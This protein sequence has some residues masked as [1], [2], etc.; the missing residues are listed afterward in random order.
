MCLFPFV[1]LVSPPLDVAQGGFRHQRS[2]LDQALCLHDLMR[3]Y[4]DRHNHYPVVAFLDIKAAYDTVDRRIIWQ[5]MLASSAPFCLVSLLANLFDDVS[6][7]VLLNNNVSTPFAPSTGVLQGSVLSPHLYSIYI[8]TLPALL[9]SAA[10]SSTTSVLT[11][12]PSGPPGPGSLVPPGL[13]FGPLA[14]SSALSSSSPSPSPINCLLYADD[15][16]LV[17]SAREVRH[18]LDLAQI[19]SLTLGYKWSPSKC[20]VLNSPVQSSR[21]FVRMSLYDEDL[22]SVDEFI[23]LGIPFCNKGISVSAMVKHRAS[24]TLFAM[25]Q[26]NAIGLNRNGFSL[27]LSARFYASFVRPKLEYGLAIAHL[28]KK[29]YTE[30]NRVQDRC[31]RMIVGGH[32]TSST[33]VLRH[34]CNLPSMDFRA[35]TLVLKYCLRVSGLPDDCLLS[36][37]ASSV[38]LSLLSRLRQRRIVHD[39]PQDASSSTSRLSSWLRR[40]RQERFNTFLQSTSR[41]LIRACRPVLRVDPVLFVPASRADR[42]RLVRWR[43][44]WLPG[45]PRPCAC[46]LGQTSRSHLV[47]CTMVPSY[48]WSCLPF[49]PTSYVGN[50]IDY[51]LNQ[52][53]LSPS[54][55]CPPFWSAL[56]TILW[57]FDRLC[58]P[59]G[60]YTT[61]PTPG[62]VWLDKSQSPS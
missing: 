62:Q 14:G 38:P 41:V 34:I 49:P 18:M 16:A 44:G 60:D 55:S 11:L 6:V 21:S 10:S 17:G 35:D 53:P 40:Y 54:A 39:C 23:Y 61:D 56:C 19:H 52:L 59:D 58:N 45:K 20:A 43:M 28:F 24:S 51:V 37:L 1:E 5:S 31:L 13:P 30:L 33:V 32:R 42:S 4:R 15:V 47:L 22:P 12:S 9:R 2:A 29:D 26:L 3:A 36:L 48:L 46:G 27:L 57:H 8:N 25:S 50:H 7:S